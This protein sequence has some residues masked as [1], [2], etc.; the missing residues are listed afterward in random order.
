LPNLVG[1]SRGL[2]VWGC[3][4]HYINNLKRS[5]KEGHAINFYYGDSFLSNPKMKA[6][7]ETV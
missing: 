5:Q 2:F 4:V 1:L 7:C 3:L 6:Y